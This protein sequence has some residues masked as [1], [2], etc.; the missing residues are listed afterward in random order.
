MY[1]IVYL[2]SNVVTTYT[3]YRFMRVFYQERNTSAAVELGSYAVYYVI[4][5]ILHVL[6]KTPIV[7]LVAN[8][9]LSFITTFN[10]ESSMKKR[11][12]TTFM[13]Y[14]ILMCIEMIVI[15]LMGHFNLEIFSKK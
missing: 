3:I 7:M 11:V 1:N 12:L 2:I 4:T 8:I 15:V 5:S 14:T 6:T 10:Y 13:I 9:I